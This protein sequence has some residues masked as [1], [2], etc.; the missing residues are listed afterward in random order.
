VHQQP[1]G[2]AGISP[3]GGPLRLLLIARGGENYGTERKLLGLLTSLPAFGCHLSVYA[4]GDGPFAAKVAALP[5]VKL[6]IDP[7]VPDRF[8]ARGS[9]RVLP[10][11]RLLGASS[12]LMRRLA[13]F[14]RGQ[15]FD[16]M[17]FCEHGLTVPIGLVGRLAGVQSFWLMPNTVSGNYP[18]DI[19]RR[20]Y[21]ATFRHLLVTP[22]ANSTF[23]R[24]TLGRGMRYCAKIDLGIDPLDFAPGPPPAAPVAIATTT[25][26]IRLLVMARLV[27]HKGQLTL[28]RAV[29]GSPDFADIHLILCGGPLGTDYAHSL[30]AE[31]AAAGAADRLH[32]V[33][34]VDDVAGYY[35]NA[36]VVVNARLDP[37]PFGLSIVEAM[38]MS[39]PVLAHALGG[40]AEIVLDGVT[41]W[42]VEGP[43]V[44]QFAVA[45]R[46]M[47]QD[48]PR[49]AA[50][51]EAGRRRAQAQYTTRA[52]AEQFA[53]VVRTH[54]QSRNLRGAG[55]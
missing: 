19:N 28:L 55:Q 26:A 49:W 25:A 4:I 38:M 6:R 20:V 47:L 33:G 1:R 50:M 40:P 5:G 21:A 46:R 31:A 30:A 27:P 43:E 34:P 24:Q 32:L 37:E 7:H 45:L 35:A 15:R 42:H 14:L 22:V 53:G 44:D 13:R 36:D 12:T 11:L 8:I 9:S 48:R 18:L 29:L 23:T 51:G 52:M 39:K 54:L 10:Y 16:A 3:V 2:D 41:G 17:V